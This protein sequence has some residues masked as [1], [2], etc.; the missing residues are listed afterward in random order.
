M[1]NLGLKE[2]QLQLNKVRPSK[3]LAESLTK[4][5]STASF[6]RLLP[7]LMVHTRAVES[8]ALLTRLSQDQLASFSSS[9]F[10]IGMVALHPQMALT[11]ASS[12]DLFVAA[13]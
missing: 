1:F 12:T 9:S 11:T 2:G 7:K 5:L 8:Q 10:F 4:N 6:H 13:S 3:N